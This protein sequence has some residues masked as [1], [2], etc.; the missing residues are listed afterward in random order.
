LAHAMCSL[1]GIGVNIYI[2][3]QSYAFASKRL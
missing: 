3:T 1:Y 2:I